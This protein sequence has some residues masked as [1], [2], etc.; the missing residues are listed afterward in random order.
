[1]RR[2]VYVIKICSRLRGGI[3]VQERLGQALGSR[4]HDFVTSGDLIAPKLL[5]LF[6]A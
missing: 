3:D 4:K 2:A 6:A 1:M 5:E